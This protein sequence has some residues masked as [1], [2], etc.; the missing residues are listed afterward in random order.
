MCTF[1]EESCKFLQLLFTNLQLWNTFHSPSLVQ[2]AVK[3]TLKDLG[4]EYLD[5]YLIHW[6]MGYKEGN[7]LF[8]QDE[9]GKFLYSDVDYVDTWKAMEELV[10]LGLVRS[11]GVSNFSKAQIERILA[12]ATI[13]PAVNQVCTQ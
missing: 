7:G 13:P 5:L 4:T 8:P 12:I 6:P 1:S 2:T 10:R 11:I 3:Q 9:N